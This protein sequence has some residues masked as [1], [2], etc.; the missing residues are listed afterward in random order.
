[1]NYFV[2]AIDLTKNLNILIVPW[3]NFTRDFFNKTGLE[4]KWKTNK[5][6]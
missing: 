6:K 5:K 1:M 4:E 3:L 2:L